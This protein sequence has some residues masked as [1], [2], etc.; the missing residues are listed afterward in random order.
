MDILPENCR[1][2]LPVLTAALLLATPSAYITPTERD[3]F[4]QPFT[5]T[6]IWNH[7]IGAA[8][9]Y[10]H[11]GL[12]RSR[13]YGVFAEEEIIIL[14]PSAP[15]TAVFENHAD[16]QPGVDR[17]TIDGPMIAKLPIP[18]HFTTQEH[19]PGTPNHVVAILQTDGRTI[20]N[21][22]PFTRGQPSSHATSHYVYPASDLYGDGIAGAHGGSG[23]SGLGGT[24]RL[25][26]LVPGGSIPH[27]MKI[28][29]HSKWYAYRWDSTPGYRWPATKADG[30]ASLLTY[31]GFVAALEMGA[32]L[33]VRPDFPMHQL[34]TAP[35]TIVA[36]AMMDYG[37]YVCD[38]AG[39]DAFYLATEWSPQGRVLDEFRQ[40]WGFDFLMQDPAHPWS[41]DIALIIEHLHVVDNN[42]A[43]SIG[44]G[45]K[46]RRQWP[47]LHPPE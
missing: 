2:I 25:G 29:M 36:Q 17:T 5:S 10:V 43:N 35:G 47:P 3:P 20:H 33:A 13:Q 9:H 23:L 46:P 42:H 24:I 44:G 11:A 18:P 22:Q 14:E 32:L 6:S 15:L 12:K 26:E 8:A 40:A 27:A 41:Q 28:V 34:Q 16:W 38:S 19:I 30:H 21:S 31:R 7:P 45:G 1:R 4:Q 39:W 37:A